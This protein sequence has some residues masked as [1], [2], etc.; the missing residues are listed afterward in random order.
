VPETPQN[1]LD[2]RRVLF[3]QVVRALD[4]AP[5]RLPAKLFYD[6]RGAALFEEITRLEEYY[7]TRT[8]LGILEACLPQVAARVGRG[9]RVVEFGTGSGEKNELLLGALER[10]HQLVLIDI[11]AEQLHEVAAGFRERHP[12]LPVVPLAADYTLPYR[13]PP[14]ANG[15]DPGATLFFFPGSTLGN[16]EPHEA[17]GFLANVAHAGGRG[18]ALLL[19]VDREKPREVV[20]PAYNDAAGVTAAFNRNAL[21]HL[22]RE[23]GGDF[24]PEA[25]EHR[26]PWNP[27]AERIEMHLVN[28]HLQHV[29]ID[30]D[31]PGER[32]F[33]F[34]MEP[35][36][37]IVTEHSYK[38]SPKRLEGLVRSAGWRIE[39]RWTDAQEW[40]DVLY[41]VR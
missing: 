40:F 30:P 6:A 36:D 21:R 7:P 27:R 9:A 33:E 2:A 39:D 35:G 32:P 5:R 26:A 41:L 34:T 18:A 17:R 29:R 16:F 25:F 3:H 20:E 10:P 23:L 11:S 12:D 8:E 22:N 15:T 1:V 28:T 24:D 13:L 38:Y 4:Q 14:R 19:G 31:L 37:V